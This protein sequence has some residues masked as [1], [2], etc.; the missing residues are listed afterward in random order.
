MPSQNFRVKNGINVGSAVT[1]TTSEYQI[2]PT[3]IH[4]SGLS[5][6]NVYITGIITAPSFSGTATTA[7]KLE[8]ARTFEITGDVVASQISFDGTGNVSLAATIQPNSVALGTDTTGDYVQSISGTSNQITVTSGTGEG[9][10]PTLSV[11]NQFTAPQDVTVTRDL[12]VNRNLN[13]TGNITIGGTSATLFTSELKVADPDIVLGIRTD[14]SGNDISNDNTANHGGIAVASTEGTPLISLYDVGVGETNPATYKKIMWFKSG[15]FSGLGTDAWLFNYGVGIGS[16][17]VPNGVRLAAG[18]VQFTENDLA[19]VRNI[20][21]SGVVTASSFSGNALS[22]TYATTAG[23][24]TSVI[25]GIG[26]ITQ[27]QVTGIST[28][29]NGP[30]LVGSGT[31]TGTTSQRLQVTGGAYVSGSVGIG[32]TNPTARLVVDGGG[33]SSIALRDDSIENHKLDSDTANISINYTGYLSGTT[34]FRDFYVYNGKYGALLRAVGSTGSILI[35]STSETGT[36]SQRLQVTGGAYVSGNIGVGETSPASKLTVRADSAGGRGGE[37]SIV[38]YATNTVGNEAALNFGLENSTYNADSGNAQIKARINNANAATDLI[39]SNWNGSSFNETVRILSNGDVGVGITNPSYKLDVSGS[40]RS[41]NQIISTQANS[42]TTGGGQIYL[43]GTTGNRIDFNTNGIAAPSFTTRSVGTKIVLYPGVSASSV[44]HAIG[45]DSGI[46]W[47]SVPTTGNAFNWYAGTT[48]VASLSGTGTFTVNGTDQNIIAAQSG[49]DNNWRGRILS[50]NSAADKAAFLGVYA[51]AP[52]VFA[53]NHALGAWATLYVNTVSG[54]DGGNVIFGSGNIAMGAATPL[55]KLDVR[56]NF[57]LAADGTTAN[58]I[59][60]K[61]YT[62]NNGTLSW[63]GSAG[64]L[65]SITNNLTSGSIFSVNDVSGIPSI[66][67]NANGTVSIAQYN[68]T[69][70]SS[71]G[72]IG[73]NS[74]GTRTLSTSTPSG[75][76]NGDI[77]YQY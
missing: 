11:P 21:A 26:S 2:G 77:W 63:E 15:T 18:S 50:K 46:M 23:V 33:S 67:V 55:Q 27:L 25:G 59:T 75:G 68:G 16:T 41:T 20:N 54:T 19:V 45:V 13:V 70:V 30:V 57:L 40:I 48:N 7:T 76:S 3:R 51:S 65:F 36:A 73:S 10:T 64:Q 58:H 47:Y 8:T 49:T 71:F 53:H 72:T 4:S 12:Q 1:I 43:N 52:G 32:M 24:S 6:E 60:Q 38:N 17:Q 74:V 28:F 14:G 9:S 44:D 39:F 22:A 42:T 31:S 69:I 61:P 5:A 34:R 29:S 56:G 66:D 37:I 62:T 35:G